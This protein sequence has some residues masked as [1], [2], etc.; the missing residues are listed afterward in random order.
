MML[1]AQLRR[2]FRKQLEKVQNGAHAYPEMPTPKATIHLCIESH[3]KAI[4]LHDD[5]DNMYESIDYGDMKQANQPKVV[6]KTNEELIDKAPLLTLLRTKQF[7]LIFVMNLLS[8]MFGLFLI[9]SSKKFGSEYLKDEKFVTLVASIAS[10]AGIFRFLFAI[11]L[12][13]F[14]YKKVYSFII[15]LQIIFAFTLLQA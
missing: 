14:S 5:E 4:R 3:G 8:V 15:I 1:N 9:G 10:I 2:F 12:D 6:A 13:K 11:G 7:I